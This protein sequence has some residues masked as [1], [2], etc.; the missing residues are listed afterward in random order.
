VELIVRMAK[1]NPLR[2]RRRI[3]MELAK[4]RFRVD[5]NTVAK[6][7]P[8][9]GDRPRR[10][11]QAWTTFIR[12]H[13]TGTIA[14]DFFTVPTVTFK[15]LYVFVVVSLERRLI[16]HVNVTAH[17]YAEWTARQ[18]VEAF[19]AD[20]HSS[21]SSATGTGSSASPSTDAS[22]TSASDSF[23]SRHDRPGK[24]ATQRGSLA[25]SGAR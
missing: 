19:G 12:T 10:P 24:T 25:R 2:S 11:S 14:V 8:K 15:I 9:S 1:E 3:A 23:A 7:L 4:L 20:V 6:Y 21:F 18:I 17:P 22:R 16:L 13:L 5:K